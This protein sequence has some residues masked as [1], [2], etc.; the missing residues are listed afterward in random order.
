M[1]EE[2]QKLIDQNQRVLKRIV[3]LCEQKRNSS[4]LDERFDAW[5]LLVQEKIL[6]GAISALEGVLEVVEENDF[7]GI[8]GEMLRYDY[9]CAKSEL[10]DYMTTFDP[11]QFQGGEGA[12]KKWEKYMFMQGRLSGILHAA[13]VFGLE[14][15]AYIGGCH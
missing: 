3:S 2:I 4:S 1:Q 10:A 15:H 14:V 12:R 5:L 7:N 8:I 6:V 13:V 11:S 9:E